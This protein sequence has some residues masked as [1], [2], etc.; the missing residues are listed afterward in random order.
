[1]P[2]SKENPPSIAKGWKAE[3]QA[4]GIAA[5]NAVLEQT[6]NEQAA[7]FACLLAAGKDKTAKMRAGIVADGADHLTVAL[8]AMAE[9]G[10]DASDAG[11]K[12]KEFRNTI[13]FEAFAPGMWNGMQFSRADVE[14]IARNFATLDAY[15]KVPLKFGHNDQQPLTDGQPALGWVVKA[16][17]NDDGKLMLRAAN[18]PDAVKRAIVEKLYRKVSIELD[19]DVEHKGKFYRYVLSGVALLGADI[20]AVN[21]LAD[22]DHYLG[23]K[24]A[25]AASRRTVFSAIEGRGKSEDFTMDEATKKAIA[26]A[27][28]AALA[29][30]QTQ[31]STQTAEI[32][33][34]TDENAKLTRERDESEK[35]KAAE[36]VA[37]ARGK[38]TEVLEAAVKQS[39]ITPG[40]REMYIKNFGIN[41]DARVVTINVDDFATMI[42]G[43]KKIDLSKESGKGSGE[44]KPTRKFE[45]SDDEIN[46]RVNVQIAQ[47]GGKLSYRRALDVVLQ[48]DPDL[49]AEYVGR[50]A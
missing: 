1:M 21:T 9:L 25:L 34:L 43:G 46:Y 29:P 44:Q 2:W 7:L 33:R 45:N 14:L 42:G 48:A 28:A 22:L 3:E 6:G 39:I 4:K 38:I 23:D 16:W 40:Q 50:A 49:A 24:P 36:K 12:R 37:L 26:D 35:V 8:E 19:L 41:D 17:V 18:V 27:V 13:D 32:K 31:M 20:P 10:L 5:A 47:A 15:H 30:M 11:G